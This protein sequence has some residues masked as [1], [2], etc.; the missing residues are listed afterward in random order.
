MLLS[1]VGDGCHSTSWS[2]AW[3]K[4]PGSGG[5][6]RRCRAAGG[7]GASTDVTAAVAGIAVLLKTT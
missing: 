5:V 7:G 6:G 3:R 2:E 4:T 1:R